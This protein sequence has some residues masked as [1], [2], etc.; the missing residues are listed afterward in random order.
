M[1]NYKKSKK[2]NYSTA[3]KRSYWIGYGMGLQNPSGKASSY[4]MSLSGRE[5][6]SFKNGLSKSRNIPV[7]D[8]NYFQ[9]KKSR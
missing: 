6:I 2:R 1:A 7:A 8:I 9:N 5:E 3:E 4:S